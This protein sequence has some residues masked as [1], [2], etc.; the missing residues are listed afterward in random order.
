MGVG[1]EEREEGVARP[2]GDFDLE[3]KRRKGD[4]VRRLCTRIQREGE[5]RDIF[6]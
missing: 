5:R 2:F 3:G 1:G 4:T 6:V